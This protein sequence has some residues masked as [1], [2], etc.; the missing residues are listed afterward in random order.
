MHK[1]T[2]VEGVIGG[3]IGAVAVAAWFL[4]IDVSMGQPF[5]TPALLGATFFDGL[6]IRLR[7]T[8]RPG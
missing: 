3:T 4:C 7:F 1:R 2:T 6:E 8:S 5:R